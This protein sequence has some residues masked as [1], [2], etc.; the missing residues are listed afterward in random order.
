MTPRKKYP[1]HWV[2]AR[3]GKR[4]RAQ[5]YRALLKIGYSD[6][7]SR[8]LRGWTF[9]HILQHVKENGRN[10]ELACEMAMCERV[11]KLME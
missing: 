10:H 11:R 8:R 2:R 3:R 9:P 6:A 5:I 4:A 7:W 1:S